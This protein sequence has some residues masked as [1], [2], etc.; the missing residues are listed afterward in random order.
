MFQLIYAS[1]A[2]REVSTSG[3]VAL[4]RA[5]R[6]KNDRLGVTGML[7]YRDGRFLQALE[8][9]EHTVRGLY[10]TIRGDDRHADVIA[11]RE[12]LIEERDFPSQTMGFRNLD[13]EEAQEATP[14]GYA[15]FMNGDFTLRHFRE[16]PSQA[17]EALLQFR[18]TALHPS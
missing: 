18:D 16:S 15:P 3:L 4:L 9:K 10:D 6:Q 14:E 8:G 13:D 5:A 12:K 1:M 11:L 7:L 2:T 17:H